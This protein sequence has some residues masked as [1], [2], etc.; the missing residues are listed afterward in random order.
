MSRASMQTQVRGAPAAQA[1]P[2]GAA[3]AGAAA[4]PAQDAAPRRRVAAQ[5][6]AAASVRLTIANRRAG[7]A[8]LG[9]TAQGRAAGRMACRLEPLAGLDTLNPALV[10]ILDPDRGER[11][12]AAAAAALA[13]LALLRCIAAQERALADRLVSAEAR[14]FALRHPQLALGDPGGDLAAALSRA[15]GLAAAAWRA[16]LPAALAAESPDHPAPIGQW[17]SPADPSLPGTRART[18][19]AGGTV[20][21]RGAAQPA[22]ALPTRRGGGHLPLARQAA[23][24]IRAL[25]GRRAVV[26][27]LAPGALS[28]ADRPARAI[29]LALAEIGPEAQGAA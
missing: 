14:G 21:G 10:P 26:L 2:P 13:G 8:A 16:R 5:A 4:P 1:A 3:Q 27:P 23:A 22:P 20:A 19:P 6:L 18:A 25:R 28:P 9:V 7:W 15:R 29:A 12:I 24:A 17:A 11:V